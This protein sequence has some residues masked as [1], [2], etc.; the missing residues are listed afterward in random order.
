MVYYFNVLYDR[1][2]TVIAAARTMKKR[3]NIQWSATKM[4]QYRSVSQRVDVATIFTLS[5]MD[6]WT[7]K[8]DMYGPSFGWFM[9]QW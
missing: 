6:L 8:L 5:G 2:W 1:I 9:S 7:R 3:R 4:A